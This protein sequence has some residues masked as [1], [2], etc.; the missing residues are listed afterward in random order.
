MQKT[1]FVATVALALATTLSLTA[2]VQDRS[3]APARSAMAARLGDCPPA[4][5]K[6]GML[7]SA[8][9]ATAP[10][11][12]PTATPAAQKTGFATPRGWSPVGTPGMSTGID[13]GVT[14]GPVATSTSTTGT[15]GAGSESASIISIPAQDQGE[16]PPS[17]ADAPGR[18][19]KGPC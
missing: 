13:T 3:G 1:A 2:C 14:R 5:G 11:S 17:K 19:A 9:Q 15:Y 8:A 18:V 4:I 10:A 7:A 6:A 16:T 12:P